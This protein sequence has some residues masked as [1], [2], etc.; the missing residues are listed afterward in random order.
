[1]PGQK[2]KIEKD[3]KRQK[4]QKRQKDKNTSKKHPASKSTASTPTAEEV[5]LSQSAPQYQIIAKRLIQSQK[6]LTKHV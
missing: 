1:M 2:T 5:S 4:G 6:F 3:K